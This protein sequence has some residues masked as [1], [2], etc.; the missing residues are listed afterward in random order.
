MPDTSNLNPTVGANAISLAGDRH[1]PAPP[2]QRPRAALALAPRN[3]SPLPDQA[4]SAFRDWL[5]IRKQLNSAKRCAFFLDFDG[6]LVNLRRRPGDVR[7]PAQ[8]RRVLKRL[9]SHPRVHVVIVSGRKLQD[10]RKLV[11]LRELRYF[12]VHGGERGRKSVALSKKSMRALQAAKRA[13]RAGLAPI[14]GLWIEDKRLSFAVHY[15]DAG[16]AAS[17]SAG[18]L[19]KSLLAPWRDS[20]HTLSGSLVWEILPREIPGKFTAVDAVLGRRRGHTAIVYVGNDG[21]DEVAFAALPGHI[22]VRVGR[23][24]T[25]LARYSLRSPAAVLR[26]LTR[27]EKELP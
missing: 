25:T 20:L 5:R 2:P 17:H 1:P 23:H 21:T 10:V 13:V 4:R 15:R 24:K 18:A 26:F 12:G 16:A 11:G 19:L 14:R 7:V 3:S 6:T 8:A 27:V 22:T 9:A